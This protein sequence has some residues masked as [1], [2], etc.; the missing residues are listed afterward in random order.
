MYLPP[1]SDRACGP[2]LTDLAVSFRDPATRQ[3]YAAKNPEFIPWLADVVRHVQEGT[4]D[5]DA[6]P[7]YKLVANFVADN[8]QSPSFPIS[9]SQQGN[10]KGLIRKM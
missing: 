9:R 6:V 10:A 1:P 3:T 5:A 8:G 4:G 7:L 2:T